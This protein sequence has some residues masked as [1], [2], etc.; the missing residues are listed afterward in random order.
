MSM[1]SYLCLVVNVNQKAPQLI[2][3][4]FWLPI[5]GR[6]LHPPP[7]L[8]LFNQ[9]LDNLNDRLLPLYM[10]ITGVV[11]RSPRSQRVA[12]KLFTLFCRQIGGFSFAFATNNGLI[13]MATNLTKS[14]DPAVWRRFDDVIE[15]PKPGKNEVQLLL[16]QTLKASFSK[17]VDE[18]DWDILLAEM[19]GFSAAQVVK[20]A[21][22]AAK[23]VIL[24]HQIKTVTQSLL[25]SAIQ[26]I[27]EMSN[28]G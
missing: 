16:I 24:K 5:A 19:E 20:V 9:F 28:H 15:L 4:G 8:Q 14:L 7:L 2:L 12:R 11:G 10:L 1:C 18:F 26:E 17:E 6:T 23:T 27:K 13:V 22:N 25:M 3:R 21:Q